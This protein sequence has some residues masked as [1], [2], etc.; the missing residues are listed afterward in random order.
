MGTMEVPGMGM[1]E[2]LRMGMT[3]VPPLMEFPPQR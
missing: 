1:M 2:V 3:E